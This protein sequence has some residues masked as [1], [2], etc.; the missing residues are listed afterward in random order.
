[1]LDVACVGGSLSV[2]R[3]GWMGVVRRDDSR[4]MISAAEGYD[5]VELE[6]LRA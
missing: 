5:D 2:G 3:E 1:M 4:G 6:D